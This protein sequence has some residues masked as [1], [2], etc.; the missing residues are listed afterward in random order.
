LAGVVRALNTL[1][2]AERQRMLRHRTTMDDLGHSLKTPLAVIRSELSAGGPDRALLAEQV[3]RMQGVIDY[4]LR[5]AA[6]SGPRSLAPRA[7]PLAP[8]AAEIAGSLEKI[9]RGRPVDWSI[10]ADELAY[11]AEQGDLYEIIGNLL[12]NAW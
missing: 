11:P 5:R 2:R 4:Q 8:L 6:A 12:D 1:L 3:R 7:V 9:H 10:D